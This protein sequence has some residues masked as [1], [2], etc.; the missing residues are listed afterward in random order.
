MGHNQ[1]SP[2]LFKLT[3]FDALFKLTHFEHNPLSPCSHNG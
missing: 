1:L 3:H 2:S